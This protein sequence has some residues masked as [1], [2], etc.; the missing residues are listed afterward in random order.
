MLQAPEWWNKLYGMLVTLVE[1]W[2]C[3]ERVMH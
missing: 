3:R 2:S 1:W